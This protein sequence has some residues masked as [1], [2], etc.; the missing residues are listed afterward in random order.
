MV[1][2]KRLSK[3]RFVFACFDPSWTNQRKHLKIY[4]KLCKK[5]FLWIDLSNQNSK[6]NLF[7]EFELHVFVFDPDI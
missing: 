6:S 2:S 5:N 7:S 3:I 1:I 4:K